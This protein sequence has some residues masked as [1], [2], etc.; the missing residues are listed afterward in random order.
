MLAQKE[1]LASVH[2]LMENIIN[3]EVKSIVQEGLQFPQA[4]VQINIYRRKIN[5]KMSAILSG[6]GGAHCP[7]CT[8]SKKDFFDLELV[9]AGYPINR[10]VSD[11]I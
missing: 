6:A 1:C 11:A 7:L 9:R 5:Y 4:H 3:T 8:A 2:H 10:T